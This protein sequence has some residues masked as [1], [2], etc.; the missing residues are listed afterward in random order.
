VE[1]LDWTAVYK[2]SLPLALARSTFD[3]VLG[4]VANTTLS[5]CFLHYLRVRSFADTGLS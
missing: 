5:C 3:F 4:T 1:R 2:V